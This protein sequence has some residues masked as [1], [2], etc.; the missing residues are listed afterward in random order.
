MPDTSKVSI[1]VAI[2]VLPVGYFLHVLKS[3]FNKKGI[4]KSTSRLFSVKHLANTD[5]EKL[6]SILEYNSV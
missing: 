6:I 5:Y 4:I 2:L 1:I 3:K